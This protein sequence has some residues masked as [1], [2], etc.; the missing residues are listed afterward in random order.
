MAAARS[1]FYEKFV[2]EIQQALLRQ[3]DIKNIEVQHD[4]TLVGKSTATHQIDVYWTFEL[5]GYRY[6]TCI[7]CKEYSSSVKKSHVASFATILD[8]LEGR[9]NGVFVTTKGYQKGAKLLAA[10]KGIRLLVLNPVLRSIGLQGRL[11]I[12]TFKVLDLRVDTEAVKVLL[13]RAGRTQLDF[14]FTLHR[15]TVLL[16][17]AGADGAK[18]NDL[19]RRAIKHDGQHVVPL[20]GYFM[21]SEIGPL[22]LVEIV[23]DRESSV[24]EVNSVIHV[25][26]DA[27]TAIL[28]D[29]LTNTVEYVNEDGTRIPHA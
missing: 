15:G 25:G 4:V 27:V 23:C 9:P 18:L 22:P 7:E 28:E 29:V 10:S 13:E 6:S 8:D 14:A 19:L 3:T 12:P 1:D 2:Q 26:N 20:A 21:A 16:D 17:A 5:A 11:T 24:V